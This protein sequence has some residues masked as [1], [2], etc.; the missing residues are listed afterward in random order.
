M[1]EIATVFGGSGFVGRYIVQALAKKGW[2]VRVAVRHPNEALFVRPYGD[3]GQVEPMLANIRNEQSV[4]NSVSGVDAVIN[5]VG[6]L[7]ETNK[8]KFNA[9][10]HEASERIARFAKQTGVSRLVQIS[11][12]GA[13]IESDSKYARTKGFGEQAVIREFPNAVIL[14]P[15][16]V[17]GPEDQ[18]F[19]R[20]SAMARYSAIIPTVSG[21]SRFQPV[22]VGD[23]AQAA[24]KAIT[25]KETS[26]IYEL[27]G[28]EIF[29]LQEL[30]QKMLKV[31]RRRR[32]VLD[33][34]LPLAHLN[35][36]AFDLLQII[37][38]GLI[39]NSLI[40]RDQIIQLRRDNIVSPEAKTLTDLEIN[41]V[42]MDSILETYLYRFRPVGQYTAIHESA[43]VIREKNI[44]N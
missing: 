7:L 26:R 43:D 22:Y 27:G 40:T 32:L 15:S 33:L 41:P 34:P 8:Q 35:A 23:V 14:R 36:T 21:K 6:I 12:I 24:T 31:I 17:F 29:T 4:I 28:P 20:F 16:I 19:N 10:H 18:F 44:P 39:K 38:G 13:D 11:S 25:S 5:C 1:A 2:R 42:A 30:M 37:S 9:I 3:P